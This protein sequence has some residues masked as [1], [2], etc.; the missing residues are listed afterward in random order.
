MNPLP[1]PGTDPDVI[2]FDLKPDSAYVSIDTLAQL[3]SV[4]TATI[5]RRISEGSLPSPH[6]VFGMQRYQVGVVRSILKKLAPVFAFDDPNAGY[7]VARFAEKD[8]LVGK[9]IA[10]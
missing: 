10:Q 8:E 9:E 2:N 1:Y 7:D 5:R 3:L 6:D 4:S